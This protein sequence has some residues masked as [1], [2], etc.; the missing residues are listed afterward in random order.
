MPGV[1]AGGERG[2]LS[3]AFAPDYVTSRLFYVYYTRTVPDGAITIDEFKR[4]A[5]IPTS[6]SELAPRGHHDSA[7]DQSNHNGGQL[8]FGPDG[9]PL[10]R[11]R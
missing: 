6:R 5:T 4:D 2:L 1:L 3:M 8:Q 9:Y 10:H 7:P 11:H